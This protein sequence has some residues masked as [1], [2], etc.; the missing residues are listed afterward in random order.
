MLRADPSQMT[1]WEPLRTQGLATHPDLLTDL[2][3][4]EVLGLF[5]SSL[6]LWNPAP[7]HLGV[8][9][10][11]EE[12]EDLVLENRNQ[13]TVVQAVICEEEDEVTL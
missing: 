6:V 12:E 13:S 7:P 8:S 10:L 3:L 9:P 5:H 11:M 2:P 4:T 1:Q